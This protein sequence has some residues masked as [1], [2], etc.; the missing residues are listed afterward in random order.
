[1]KALI[2]IAIASVI[3]CMLGIAGSASNQTGVADDK[4]VSNTVVSNQISPEQDEGTEFMMLA[5]VA[6]IS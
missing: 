6:A 5:A 1:M 2:A 4:T 3:A